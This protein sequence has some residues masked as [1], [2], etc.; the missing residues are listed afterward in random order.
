M[1]AWPATIPAPAFDG[2]GISPVD[3]V[4]RSDQPSGLRS[5]RQRSVSRQ[6]L[7][8]V[9][10][11][12]TEAEFAVFEAWHHHT[13]LDGAAWFSVSLRNGQGA[14][15]HTARFNGPWEATP[16]AGTGTWAVS[17]T[18]RVQSRPVSA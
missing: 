3:G 9:R 6:S 11:V 18:L 17:G 15:T 2:Y 13:V 14:S 16:L 8:N 10:W 5:A 1:A 4:L 7:I 12:F